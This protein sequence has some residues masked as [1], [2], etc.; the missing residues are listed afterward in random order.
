MGRVQVWLVEAP[1]R[2]A[3][4]P[5]DGRRLI[6]YVSILAA[7]SVLELG[8][9]PTAENDFLQATDAVT[10][11]VKAYKEL[12]GDDPRYAAARELLMAILE[13]KT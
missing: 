3:R 4:L 13:S 5:R 9:A 8:A 2:W 10:T 6:S 11:A 7:L 1:L 12:W